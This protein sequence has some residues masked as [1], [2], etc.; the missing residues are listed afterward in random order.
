MCGQSVRSKAQ[1]FGE[2]SRGLMEPDCSEEIEMCDL[3]DD[4]DS[5]AIATTS[6]EHRSVDAVPRPHRRTTPMSSVW[7]FFKKA[8]DVECNAE[9]AVCN[10]CGKSLFIPKTR[11]TSNLL[12]HLRSKHKAEVEKFEQR[13]SLNKNEREKQPKIEDV[14]K[15]KI[16]KAAKED[17]DRKLIVFLAKASLPLHVTQLPSFA[18]LLRSLHPSYATPSTKTLLKLMQKEVDAIDDDNRRVSEDAQ[19]AITVDEWSS[20]NAS[21]SLLAITGHALGG[22]FSKRI[23]VV[24]D[25]APLEEDSH[26]S[27]LVESKILESLS[28]LGIAKER[29][30]F[31]IADGASV[32]VKTA[33]D[34]GIQY[35]HCCAHVINLSVA[36]ALNLPMCAHVLKKVKHVVSKLNKSGK[37]KKMFRQ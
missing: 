14:F 37:L 5:S 17:I 19:I 6:N 4:D 28:R 18:E 10:F 27:E 31:M 30:S 24:L 25:C 20:K 33:S 34:L 11:T 16:G 3:H 29:V 22:D 36:A 13:A 9:T 12:H 1:G 35:I 21:C 8:V 23:N 15:R 7:N 26:T 2:R 32:M